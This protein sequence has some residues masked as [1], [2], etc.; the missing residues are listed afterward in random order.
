MAKAL[1]PNYGAA[2]AFRFLCALFAAAPMT[3]TGGTVGDIWFPM[4][5]PFGLPF[6]TFGAYAGPILGPVIGAYAPKLGYNWADWI[7]VIV[8]GATA[9]FVFLAQPETFGPLLLEW[10]AKHL[11]DLTGD[12]RYRA[13]HA[14][15]ASLGPRLVTNLYRP[16][17]MI[18]TEPIILVFSFYLILLYFVLFTFLSGYPYIFTMVYDISLGLT[19]ILWV[20]MIPGLIIAIAMIPYMYHLTKKAATKAA[21]QG[22][23]LQPEVSLYWAM[24]G[25]SILMPVSLFWM[26]W[27][28][29]VSGSNHVWAISTLIVSFLQ[30]DISI[31]SPILAS[32]V[33]GYSLVCIF[34]TTYMYIIFVY[35]QYAA[36][37]LTF[38]TFS[39]YIV[40]GALTPAAVKMYDK[41]GPH[42]ALTIS[43]IV[44]TTMAPVPFVLYKYGHKIRAMSKNAQNK[45]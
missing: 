39:R 18:W 9:V 1:A 19:F 29:Y 4:Q 2:I 36:S 30:S 13:E 32:A 44:A 37:A 35:L 20:A 38:A 7:S 25:A 8:L 26:A 6:L 41:I 23:Q 34:T 27:T 33:F 11:R 3:V 12:N 15:A 21:S 43:A 24:A 14:S 42:W 17:T 31:W 45:A 40:A 16:F 5:I 28:C 10:R 22:K